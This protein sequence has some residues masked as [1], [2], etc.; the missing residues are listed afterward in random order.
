MALMLLRI[1]TSRRWAVFLWSAIAVQV[2]TAVG[3]NVSQLTMWV[4]VYFATGEDSEDDGGGVC[5]G[6]E[7]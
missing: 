6:G 3:V 2:G 1:K 4:G 5:G 7:G